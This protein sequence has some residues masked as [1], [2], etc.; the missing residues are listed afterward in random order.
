MEEFLEPSTGSTPVEP[1]LPAGSVSTLCPA[2]KR[3]HCTSE[4]WCPKQHLQPSPDD[5][6]LPTL[7]HAAARP[8]CATGWRRAGSWMRL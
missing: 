3:G 4:G 7:G 1:P 2:W 6:A 5:G 8:P